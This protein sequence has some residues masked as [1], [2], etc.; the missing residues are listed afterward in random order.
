MNVFNL[1][2]PDFNF[3]HSPD[4]HKICY[5]IMHWSTGEKQRALNEMKKLTTTV[6]A[7]LNSRCHFLYASW[8][9]EGD[10]NDPIDLIKEAYGHLKIVV[11]SFADKYSS[12]SKIEVEK[13]ISVT[14]IG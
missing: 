10:D 8:L 3:E 2:S 9:L 7:P 5:V 11:D 12:L 6:S 14:F 4:L 1:L 13:S